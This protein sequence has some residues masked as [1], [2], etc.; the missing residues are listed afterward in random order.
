V[1]LIL[2]VLDPQTGAVRARLRLDTP[3]FTL[4]R[5]YGNDLILDDPYVDAR[6]ARIT[7]TAEG[8]WQIEDL[9]SLNGLIALRPESSSATHQVS[10]PVQPGT[11][12]RV[13][14]TTLRFRDPDEPVAA[15]LPDVTEPASRAG[16]TSRWL[17]TSWVRL[18]MPACALGT[19]ALYTW[20]HS[21]ERS[22]G[23]DAFTA[24]LV[25]LFGAA[26]WAGVW[27]VA[28]R[29]VVH[30]FHF[31]EH[32]AVISAIV[33]AGLASMI[34]SEWAAFLFPDNVLLSPLGG[35][36]MLVT[37]AALVAGHLALASTMTRRRRWNAGMVT[38]GVLLALGLIASLAADD[39]FSDVP[40]FPGVLKPFRAQWVPAGSIEGFSRAVADLKI[41]VDEIV[42]KQK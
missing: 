12:V 11:Q 2:E 36:L 29:I 30:R 23:S 25:F 16:L 27:S 42:E 7:R 24:G 26:L 40:E 28:S 5:G 13:G 20:L 19:I 32:V 17:T 18:G 4:G 39:T 22:S 33:L 31:L 21:F 14:R 37:V 41:E 3:A 38:S 34:F 1:A 10:V 35:A 8:A 6:H 15:A 9:G